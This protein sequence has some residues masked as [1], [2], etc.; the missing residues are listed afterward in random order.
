[1]KRYK[2]VN[3][4]QR[5]QAKEHATV[6]EDTSSSPTTWISTSRIFCLIISGDVWSITLFEA[7]GQTLRRE[8]Q[9]QSKIQRQMLSL[10]M[11]DDGQPVGKNSAQKILGILSLAMACCL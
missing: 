6:I 2:E 8:R 11:I 10:L 3:E 7:H 5:D 1:M 4:C 9:D